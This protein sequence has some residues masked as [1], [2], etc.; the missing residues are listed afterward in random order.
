MAKDK[1]RV[2]RIYNCSKQLVP[3]Q[4]KP[5]GA[6]FY[7]SESQ[8][9]L[10]PGQDTLLPYSH[11]RW[12]QIENLQRRGMIRILYDSETAKER[13]AVLEEARQTKAAQAVELQ[14]HRAD[15]E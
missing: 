4:V 3:L 6:D 8:V 13:E 5:P 14:E 15:A 7:T 11:L 10:I 9:R 1:S 12:E 2:V